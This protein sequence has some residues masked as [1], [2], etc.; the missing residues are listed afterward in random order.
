M[1]SFFVYGPIEITFEYRPG[2]RTLIFKDFW[3]KEEARDL[4]YERGCYVFA[5]RNRSLTPIYIGKATKSFK[6]ETFNNSNKA[7]YHDGFSSYGKGT[8]LMYFVVHPSQSGPT[9]NTDIKNI[10]NFLIQAGVAANPLIQ[11]IQGTKRPSWS[12][13]GVIRSAAGKPSIEETKFRKMFDINT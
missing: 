3:L 1:T 7:K 9:N 5:M 13:K 10:E 12:I 6:Q 2:G 4:A 8:P 11:N